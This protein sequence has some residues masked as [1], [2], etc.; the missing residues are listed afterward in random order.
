LENRPK[1]LSQ[2]IR[3]AADTQNRAS[4]RRQGRQI[5]YAR[6]STDD[7]ATEAQEMEL[8][9][10]GCDAIVEEHGSGASR[11]RPALSKLL[12]EIGAGDTLVVVRLDRLARSVS[13][14]LEVIEDLCDFPLNLKNRNT[15]ISSRYAGT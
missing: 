5:G 7:Q 3:M 8:R 9:A 14:L 12:R 13:H 10:A 1:A 11:A 15:M 4:R 2:A 6:V